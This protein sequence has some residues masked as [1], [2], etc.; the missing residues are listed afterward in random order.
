MRRRFRRGGSF[1]GRRR[2]RVMRGRRRRTYSP[3]LR[4]GYRM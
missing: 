4:I 2:G 3:K 1:R